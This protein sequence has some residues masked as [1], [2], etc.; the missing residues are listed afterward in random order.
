MEKNLLSIMGP[1]PSKDQHWQRV[2]PAFGEVNKCFI[3]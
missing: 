3:I 1:D 2:E